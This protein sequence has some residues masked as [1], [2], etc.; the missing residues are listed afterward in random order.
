MY[1]FVY[2]LFPDESI[3][4]VFHLRLCLLA[5]K[6]SSARND[7]APHLAYEMHF[8][9]HRFSGRDEK[10]VYSRTAMCYARVSEE[11]HRYAPYRHFLFVALWRQTPN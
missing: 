1:F 7:Q 3:Q 2:S 11:S 9:I 6:L 5:L 4:T 8:S 10:A